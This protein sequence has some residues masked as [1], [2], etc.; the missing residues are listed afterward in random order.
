MTSSNGSENFSLPTHLDGVKK[1]FDKN[2]IGNSPID[3]N[4]KVYLI[5]NRLCI[6]LG[7]HLDQMYSFLNYMLAFF[8]DKVPTSDELSEHLRFYDAEKRNNL[9][10]MVILAEVES[11]KTKF[12][13]KT[14]GSWHKENHETFEFICS[15]GSGVK[16]L[17]KLSKQYT[18]GQG[19]TN[20]FNKA[21]TQNLDFLSKFIGNECYTADSILNKWGAGFEMTYFFNGSFKKLSEYT[22]IIFSGE[23]D[24]SSGLDLFPNSILKYAYKENVLYI[25]AANNDREKMF[26]VKPIDFDNQKQ[27]IDYSFVP[28]Y[29]SK[30]YILTYMIKLPDGRFYQ[31]S[32]VILVDY[33]TNVRIRVQDKNLLITTKEW[34]NNHI[35]SEIRKLFE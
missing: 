25:R 24:F 27:N 21:L 20:P 19:Y 22:Y 5:N 32:F 12:N 7:G 16:D 34:L 14:I 8:K 4:Q 23:F 10:A 13:I 33:Q 18:G 26:F 1:V 3:L 28:D 9:L 35:E 17:I 15:S 31:P 6:L 29:E 2:I 30:D 11:G